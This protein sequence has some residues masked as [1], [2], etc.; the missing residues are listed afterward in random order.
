M[1]AETGTE[2]ED[3]SL[4]AHISVGPN[5]MARFWMCI[6]FSSLSSFTLFGPLF[7]DSER[8]KREQKE[9][10]Y[11]KQKR[12]KKMGTAA[13]KE[14]HRDQRNGRQL[15]LCALLSQVCFPVNLTADRM[16]GGEQLVYTAA[17]C[18]LFQRADQKETAIV[19]Q[20]TACEPHIRRRIGIGLTAVSAVIETSEYRD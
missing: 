17:H 4:S 18:H 5:T 16:A 7:W 11:V 20:V 19:K 15:R 8:R 6:R 14:R 1:D 10:N 13:A 3:L 12:R 2:T 9:G